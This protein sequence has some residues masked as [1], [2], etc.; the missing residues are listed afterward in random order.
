MKTKSIFIAATLSVLAGVSIPVNAQI[1][2]MPPTEAKLQKGVVAGKLDRFVL[3]PGRSSRHLAQ[4]RRLYA[5]R[6]RQVEAA[7]RHD[8]PRWHSRVS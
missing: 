4:L 6:V 7:S 1:V 3:P 5:L 2:Y 8:L